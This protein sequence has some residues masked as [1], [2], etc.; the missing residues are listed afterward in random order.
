MLSCCAAPS[1]V[2]IARQPCA[3]SLSV[4]IIRRTSVVGE[5]SASKRRRLERNFSCSLEKLNFTELS[6]LH[7]TFLAS[8]AGTPEF[9]TRLCFPREAQKHLLHCVHLIEIGR[10]IV[11][12]A[13][14]AGDKTEASPRE[15]LG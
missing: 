13:V 3:R 15:G 12:A 10:N 5:R 7:I 14:F 9:V 4:S 1:T 2:L 11:F 8:S 6:F